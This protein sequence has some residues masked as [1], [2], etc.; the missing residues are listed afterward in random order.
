[1]YA[2]SEETLFCLHQTVLSKI[3]AIEL[4][5]ANEDLL[6]LLLELLH[7]KNLLSH[8]NMPSLLYL[9]DKP[10]LPV[11]IN[12]IVGLDSVDASPKSSK[13]SFFA[14]EIINKQ[15]AG[16]INLLRN[17]ASVKNDDSHLWEDANGLLQ[18]A[19]LIYPAYHKLSREINSGFCVLC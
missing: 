6:Q 8:P 9:L 10:G 18:N 2:K 13:G 17:V 15:H 16:C 4:T 12:Y 5:K 19:L 7:E 14:Q 1:M 11:L 3:S